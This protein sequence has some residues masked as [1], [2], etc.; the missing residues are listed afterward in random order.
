MKEAIVVPDATV[1][2]TDSP[3]P[4]PGPHQVLVKVIVAGTNPKDWKFPAFM[5]HA[6]NSGDDLAG[7]VEAVGDKVCEFRKGDRVAGMHAFPKPH[8]A[9]VEYAVLDDYMTFRIPETT[10]FEEA[11]TIPLALLTAAVGLFWILGLP[12]PWQQKPTGKI[13]LVIYGAS[14]AVASFAVQLARA[15]QIHPII[16]IG[17][18]NSTFVKAYLD[19]S[20][21]DTLLDYRAF[22]KAELVEA[23][24]AAVRAAGI[25]S[26]RPAHAYDTISARGTFDAVLSKAMAGPPIDGKK[27]KIAVVQPGDDYSTADPSVEIGITNCIIGHDGSEDSGRFAAVVFRM[28]TAGLVHG[29]VKGHPFEVLPGGLK[30]VERALKASKEGTIRAKKLLLRVGDTADSK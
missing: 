23:V 2:I 27:P 21:G 13:P 24:Q 26:G 5:N 15:A 25:P 4:S 16:A 14:T 18:P 6:H 11:A 7:V 1:T 29:W 17:S 3:I 19:V 20:K 30:A 12:A 8:G 9:F 22:N 10:T 28:I